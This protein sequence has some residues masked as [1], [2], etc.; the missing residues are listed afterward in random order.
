MRSSNHWMRSLSSCRQSASTRKSLQ[1]HSTEEVL[2]N[3]QRISANTGDIIHKQ[4]LLLKPIVALILKLCCPEFRSLPLQEIEKRIEMPSALGIEPIDAHNPFICGENV[5]VNDDNTKTVFDSLFTAKSDFGMLRLNIEVQAAT[6][7][8]YDI[9]NRG[10]YYIARVISAEKTKGVFKNSHYD[11]LQKVYSIWLMTNPPK[12]LAGQFDVQY[13]VKKRWNYLADETSVLEDDPIASKL[14]FVKVYLPEGDILAADGDPM[15]ILG[16]TF[17]NFAS[18]EKKKTF[19]EKNGI[20][21]NKEFKETLMKVRTFEDSIFAKGQEDAMV[22]VAKNL[23]QDGC[24]SDYVKKITG[25]S[26]TT[27][28]RLTSELP[29]PAVPKSASPVPMTQTH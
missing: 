20:F 27:I 15:N 9:D 10:I 7:P 28:S 26:K 29:P 24:S 2:S 11:G 17:R 21:V 1:S 19:L 12:K 16:V 4:L 8:R 22:H 18:V 3:K 6:Y 14:C 13:L 5:E 23:L 25:L